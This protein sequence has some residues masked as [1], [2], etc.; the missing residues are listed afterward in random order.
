MLNNKIVVAIV[1]FLIGTP[2]SLHAQTKPDT[3]K[4][5]KDSAER[6]FKCL[7]HN[8]ILARD[9]DYIQYYLL[10]V[11]PEKEDPWI[12]YYKSNLTKKQFDSMKAATAGLSMAEA[13]IAYENFLKSGGD[14]NYKVTVSRL[15]KSNELM[16]RVLLKYPVLVR[17][18]NDLFMRLLEQTNSVLDTH[19]HTKKWRK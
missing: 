2:Y 15:F 9:T 19:F 8:Q 11:K 14:P 12:W 18:P 1:I 16:R 4:L 13:K 7:I 5:P 6:V 10:T 17:L 3:T